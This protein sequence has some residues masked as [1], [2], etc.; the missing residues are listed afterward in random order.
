MIPS[1]IYEG[2][3]QCLR[4]QRD[5]VSTCARWVSHH[6]VLMLINMQVLNL[7]LNLKRSKTNVD[8]CFVSLGHSFICKFTYR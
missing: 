8:E 3:N 5:T 1:Q 2:V 6:E 4:E 7:I